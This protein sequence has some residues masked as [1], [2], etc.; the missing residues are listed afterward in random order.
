M[1]IPD[2]ILEAPEPVDAFPMPAPAPDPEDWA[3]QEE[4]AIAEEV[5]RQ[6]HHYAYVSPERVRLE[7]EIER[8]RSRMSNGLL[9]T[10]W[11]T[12]ADL[13]EAR[14]AIR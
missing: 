6:S 9:L 1:T 7:R 11:P 8:L 3:E 12:A 14:E 10:V 2:Y 4:R 13:H 5:A